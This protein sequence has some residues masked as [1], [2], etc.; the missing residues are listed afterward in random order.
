MRRHGVTGLVLLALAGAVALG[1]PRETAGRVTGDKVRVRAGPGTIHSRLG[2][3]NRDDL[4]VVLGREGQWMKVLLPG[5]FPCFIHGSLVSRQPDGSHQVSGSRV[6]MRVTAGKEIL[7]LETVLDR[8]ERVDVLAKEGDWLRIIPPARTHAYVF[9]E[10][11]EELGPA[12]EYQRALSEQGKRRRAALLGEATPET[13]SEKA[14]ARQREFRDLVVKTGASVLA[15]EGDTE[16]LTNTLRRIVLESNDDLTRGYSESLL[17][18]L[19][20]RREAENLRADLDRVDTE[21]ADQ[22]EELTAK[23]QAADARYRQELEK[24]RALRI[25]RERPYRQVGVVEQR[26]DKFVLVVKNAPV[27]HLLSTR[28]RLVEYV[29]KRVGVN[30]RMVL[31]D[32]DTGATHLMV[33]KLEILPASQSG[34]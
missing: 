25:L 17:L 3:L 9:A 11:V 20:L 10:Y 5:G 32:P 15:G 30:G 21:R 26:G 19:G 12:A 27:L 6:R 22:V 8:G 23:A 31:T 33:E 13:E 24:A 7:P 16:E 14:A 1:A 29:G 28:F 18:L 4:V 34:R 2:E